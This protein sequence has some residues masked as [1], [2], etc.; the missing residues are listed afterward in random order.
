LSLNAVNL[1]GPNAGEF[2]QSHNCPVGGALAAGASCTISS[3][4]T[5]AA[6]GARAATVTLTS[7][8]TGSPAVDLKGTGMVQT[9][10]MAQ[11]APAQATFG[12]VRIG[13]SSD[14]RKIRVRNTGTSPLLISSVGVT[15]DFI[16][17]SDC[18]S[19]LA[20]GKSCEMNVKFKPTAAGART[21]ELSVASNATG[22]PHVV[23]LSG[24]GVIRASREDDDEC[25]DEDKCSQVTLPFT[26][27]KKD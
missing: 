5:P 6:E 10:A 26:R 8:A 13:K 3:K 20:A 17:E 15:G 11:V 25:D 2:S 18:K 14:E 23:K 21:G 24:I 27:R 4:F 22:A 19:S 12:R 7:N 1:A 9:S 16:Y